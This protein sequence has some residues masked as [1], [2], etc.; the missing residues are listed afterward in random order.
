MP[1]WQL[2]LQY[3]R[4]GWRSAVRVELLGTTVLRI[5]QW[6][7]QLILLVLHPSTPVP[8]PLGPALQKWRQNH[9]LATTHS[10]HAHRG[11]FEEV[12]LR[13]PPLLRVVRCQLPIDAKVCCLRHTCTI[14]IPLDRHD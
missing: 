3:L 11:E 13:V 6:R 12:V 7:E 1:C 4:L 10:R 5:G 8:P 9:Q 14:I 2:L